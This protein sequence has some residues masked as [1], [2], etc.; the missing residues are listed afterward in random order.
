MTKSK[1]GVRMA[2]AAQ[3]NKAFNFHIN[4]DSRVI[5][6]MALPFFERVEQALKKEGFSNDIEPFSLPTGFFSEFEDTEPRA[7][8]GRTPWIIGLSLFLGSSLRDW[9][10]NKGLDYV[11]EQKMQP[12][13]A[14]LKEHY[15]TEREKFPKNS[16]FC[17]QYGTW[18]AKDEIYLQLNIY[19]ES[20]EDLAHLKMVIGNA[21]RETESMIRHQSLSRK[22]VIFTVVEG[23][24]VG[25]PVISNKLLQLM[26]NHTVQQR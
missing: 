26:P 24:I 17:F 10:T 16:N 5:R 21:E 20:P 7:A 1:E 6:S 3:E 11:F 4:C 14:L 22:V 15:A 2:S 18:Y 12:A 9:A 8:A 23:K 25:T 13:I 19:V